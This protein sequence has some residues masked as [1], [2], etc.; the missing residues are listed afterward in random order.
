MAY[1]DFRASDAYPSKQPGAGQAVTLYDSQDP[2]RVIVGAV[3]SF[4]SR[5]DL[6]TIPIEEAGNDGV[7]EIAQGRH[8]GSGSIA[9]FFSA[10]T[11]DNLPTRQS[12]IGRKFTVLVVVAPGRPG[13]GTVLNAYTGLALQGVSTSVGARG[14]VTMDSSFVYERRYNG[15]EWAALTGA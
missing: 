12:F 4:S 9:C 14:A 15:T 13:E 11:N 2:T 3:T 1:T 8:S 10:E 7:D 6:E 5:D